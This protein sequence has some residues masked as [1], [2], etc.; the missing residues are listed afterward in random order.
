MRALKK[1]QMS[2]V[3]PKLNNFHLVVISSTLHFHSFTLFAVTGLLK[4]LFDTPAGAV[5]TTQ[6]KEDWRIGSKAAGDTMSLDKNASKG[7]HGI[8]SQADES[9]SK[10]RNG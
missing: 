6:E 5:N 2:Q 7:Q 4:G 9:F 8:F 10:Y 3:R 1:M